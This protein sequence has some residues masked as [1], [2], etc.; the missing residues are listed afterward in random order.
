VR[1]TGIGID[2]EQQEI[3]FEAFR[4]ADGGTH[5]KYGG[6][7]LGLSISRELAQR[8]GGDDPRRQRSA[9]AAARS[10]CRCREWRPPTLAAAGARGRCCGCPSWPSGRTRRRTRHHR[11]GAAARAPLGPAGRPAGAQRRERRERRRPAARRPCAGPPAGAPPTPT[12]ACSLQPGTRAILV[13]RGRPAFAAILRDLARERG[14][15]C[16]VATPPPR[17]A[18]AAALRSRAPSCWT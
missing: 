18:C 8:L 13:D 16:V 6:T 9:A 5:R 7:G 14:F 17:L 11:V 2:P 4:Q 15:R 10:R 1:D 3:I 12:T